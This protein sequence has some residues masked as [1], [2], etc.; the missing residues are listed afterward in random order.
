M[1]QLQGNFSFNA[2]T[3]ALP[4]GA[5]AATERR[6]L[7][8]NDKPVLALTQGRYR[9]YIFPLYTPAGFLVATEAPA[10]HPHH[11]SCWIAADHFHCKMPAMGGRLEDYTYNFYLDQTFQGR[12]AGSI[13]ETGVIGEELS[14]SAFRLVQH[15]EWRGPSEWAA[16]A[17]RIAARETRTI[18]IT[19]LD[20]YY[21]IDIVSR[22]M[23]ADWNLTIGP[24]RHSYFNVRVAESIA[25]TSGSGQVRND[26]GRRGTEITGDGSRWVDYCGGVGGGH[27]AGVAVIPAPIENADNCWFVTDWGVITVGP[28]RNVAWSVSKDQP[29]SLRYRILV[30]DGDLSDK[31]ID[32]HC[33]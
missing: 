2:D 5:W 1:T 23:A 27:K 13:V 16:P 7:R 14:A 22:L 11:N 32:S 25:V 29:S 15:L 20:T 19:A 21:V 30:H 9:N 31:V 3:I 6:T 8:I 28:F 18:D 12:A 24:T 10:D 17:G 33:F 26:R 4:S